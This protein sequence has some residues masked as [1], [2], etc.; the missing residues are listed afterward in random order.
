MPRITILSFLFGAIFFSTSLAS[1]QAT[2]LYSVDGILFDVQPDGDL[3]DGGGDA[4]DGCFYLNVGGSSFPYASPP[5]PTGLSGRQVE[6]PE[7][8]VGELMVRRLV[9]V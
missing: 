5:I 6:L 8:S 4:Y 1:A 2:N 3:G 7:Q 9:Y